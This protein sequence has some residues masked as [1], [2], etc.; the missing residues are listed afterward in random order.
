MWT[1]RQFLA[2]GTSS[3]FAWNALSLW[4]AGDDSEKL[5]DGSMA[6]GMITPAA[7]Q[8]I[9]D[10]L[11]FLIN[12][13]DKDGSFGT[14]HHRGNVAITSLAGLAFM[15]GGHFPGRGAHGQVVQRALEFV[16]SQESTTRPGYLYNRPVFQQQDG[17]MYSHGFGTL[18]LAEN[19]GMVQ[20]KKLRDRQQDTL[21]RAVDLII[22]S[23][24]PKGG[25][26]YYPDS[27]DA[28]ISVTICQIMALRAARNACFSVPKETVDRCIKY[29]KSCQE[30]PSS[31]EAGGF[32]YMD[33]GGSP[34]FARTAAGVVAL[35]CAGQYKDPAVD[36]GLKYLMQFKPKQYYARADMHY[37]YGHYYAAQ[38]MW[39]AGGN[40]WAEWYPAIRDELISRTHRFRNDGSWA[41]QICT[42]YATAMAC[43]I[44]QIPNNYLPILQK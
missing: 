40:Y 20:D 2:G 38:A 35:Y 5:P 33:Q 17:P 8:A 11:K 43:I 10:G 19:H 18:F 39:T 22:A 37:F 32:R 34:A 15:A 44:L 23:Q 1:R 14:G 31:R 24:N 4:G 27:K 25:W 26:R 3:L 29:V 6:K 12:R 42:H 16:L 28:D 41:D 21:K 13:Q 7:Q 30:P 9:Q 36:S